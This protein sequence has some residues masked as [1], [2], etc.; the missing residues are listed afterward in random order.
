MGEDWKKVSTHPRL[1]WQHLGVNAREE[2]VAVR[3]IPDVLHQ[4]LVGGTSAHACLVRVEPLPH[5]TKVALHG[6]HVARS[7]PGLLV[8]QELLEAEIVV[9]VAV[10]AVDLAVDGQEDGVVVV[11][12][13]GGVAVVPVVASPSDVAA[14]EELGAAVC[15]TGDV[16]LLVV[17]V[18][19]PAFDCSLTW[20]FRI[21]SE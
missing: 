17:P 16:A 2:T 4:T 14:V 19:G 9:V 3:R 15:G 18:V 11:A 5:H 12:G 1:V 6:G 10:G 21:R 20:H 8:G 13:G 7:V